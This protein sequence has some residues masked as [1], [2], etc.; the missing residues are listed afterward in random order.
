MRRARRPQ[1]LRHKLLWL[2][3]VRG[4]SRLLTGPTLRL[5]IRLT[6]RGYPMDELCSPHTVATCRAGALPACVTSDLEAGWVS[7][8][9]AAI[10]QQYSFGI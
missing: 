10:N 4:G 9:H 5:A 6:T 1:M 7:R 2:C 8:Q 3:T